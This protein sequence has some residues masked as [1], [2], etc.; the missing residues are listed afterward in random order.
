MKM[1]GSLK[2]QKLF[3]PEGVSKYSHTSASN[4]HRD[5]EYRSQSF[6]QEVH[7]PFGRG[8]CQGGIPVI[9]TGTSR[10]IRDLC[11]MV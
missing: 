1:G 7:G 11:G 2:L 10:G 4:G 5:G 6:S 8:E 9:L 3:K